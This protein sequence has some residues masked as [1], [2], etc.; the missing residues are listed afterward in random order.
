[1]LLCDM[2]RPARAIA[3][4]ACIIAMCAA[5]ASCQ[6]RPLYSQTQPGGQTLSQVAFSPATDRLSQQVR[7]HLIFLAGNGAGESQN[8]LY[9]LQLTSVTSA[10]GEVLTQSSGSIL[11]ARMVV[12]ATYTLKSTSDDSVLQTKTISVVSL[13]DV[14]VQ[15]FAK[16]RAIRD[17][18][19]RAAKEAAEQ[20]RADLAIYFGTKG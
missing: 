7:N 14:P 9:E 4:A 19:D 12:S 20:I 11:P 3:S 18:E 2:I 8:P 10:N 5:L 16:I 15:Q 6:V 17:A 13:F 1:M